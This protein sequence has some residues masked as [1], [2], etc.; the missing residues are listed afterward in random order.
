MTLNC[1]LVVF[2]VVLSP[3]SAQRL[4]PSPIKSSSNV[5]VAVGQQ[6]S[7]K[8]VAVTDEYLSCFKEYRDTP[9]PNF[10][11]DPV[12]EKMNGAA[13]FH[14]PNY[15]SWH[16]ASVM[17]EF[18]GLFANRDE[19]PEIEFWDVSRATT[20]EDMFYNA[21]NFNRS[22]ARW[23]TK[24]ATNFDRFLY[25]TRYNDDV[26]IAAP[27][28][29]TFRGMLADTPDFNKR[30]QIQSA[31]RADFS[32]LLQNASSFNNVLALYNLPTALSVNYILYD[33]VAFDQQLPW[34]TLNANASVKAAL[35]NCPSMTWDVSCWPTLFAAGDVRT[36]CGAANLNATYG[37]CEKCFYDAVAEVDLFPSRVMLAIVFV[38]VVILFVSSG[39]YIDELGAK[40]Q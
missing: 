9:E 5:G 15:A 38:S 25:G 28:A 1:W 40:D 23:N 16:T 26:V 20:F 6:C 29:T 2:V 34:T 10:S 14:Y 13:S 3:A 11:N 19:N 33:A 4:S 31:P 37:P 30:V 21:R 35:G 39:Q 17:V 32:R 36:K 12:C 18:E 22:I 24:S 7:V 8:L 27:Y